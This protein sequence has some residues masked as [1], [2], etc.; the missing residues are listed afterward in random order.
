MEIKK[1]FLLV[2]LFQLFGASAFHSLAQAD[3]GL[4]GMCDTYVLDC[5]PI[6]KTPRYLGLNVEVMP[7]ASNNNVWNWLVDSNTKMVRTPHPAT[8]LRSN[9]QQV[10]ATFS[11]IRS[12]SDFNS[13]RAAV[14][15]DPVKEVKWENYLFS[16]NLPW[17]GNLDSIVD[18][19]V[20][21]K[22]E[23]L[24]AMSYEPSLYPESVLK[25]PINTVSASD[26]VINWAAAASAYEY[27]FACAYRYS[28]KG[29]HYFMMRNEPSITDTLL[30]QSF[31][32][33]ARMARLAIDDVMKIR[34]GKTHIQM[35]GPAV[36]L[37]YE[38][39]LRYTKDYI[40]ILDVH[41]YETSGAT[42][43]KKLRRGLMNA[44][45]NDL[46]FALTEFGRIG[47]ATDIDESLFGMKASLQVA[48][49]IMNVLSVSQIEDPSFE[50][51]LFYQFQFPATHR[52]YKSL[53]YGDMNLVDWSGGDSPLRSKM[54][55]TPTLEQLQLRNPTP[56][57]S[58]F[59]MLAR[60]TPGDDNKFS[61]YPVFELMEANR[62]VT[63]THEKRTKRNTWPD[64][65]KEK[66]Y[67]NEGYPFNIK[68]LVVKSKD[69]LYINILNQEPASLNN[70]K[71]DFS[72]FPDKYVTAVVRETSLLKKDE[73]ISQQKILNSV[74]HFDI[75]A[76]SFI[77]IIL[78]KDDL[79][80]ITEIR[81]NMQDF[82][83]VKVDSL[84]KFE[85][86]LLRVKGKIANRWIDI[87]DLNVKYQVSRG[88]GFSVNGSGLLQKLDT[89]NEGECKIKAELLNRKCSLNL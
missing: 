11:W 61:S 68:S 74:V 1:I 50:M 32:V 46:K 30:M 62:G 12:K 56:A 3:S 29:C 10:N 67:A 26:G 13:Y 83:S 18:K 51:A 49:L 9:E 8:I 55:D 59:K 47:G 80:A 87:S 60:C 79:D 72:S 89:S 70:I 33:L 20:K 45:K 2:F 64:L 23:P 41:N 15:K 27:Y 52:N 86:A 71:I 39:Y 54:S 17:L 6:A 82:T 4:P 69:R 21:C 25:Q 73:P 22:I 75:P 58:I 66:Y 53:V 78:V 7:Y 43:R 19:L 48:D 16:K 34:G 57:Y 81:W 5:I 38:E 85:T 36:Y 40:D 37:A 44:R 77:Q 42:L 35:L 65:G 84:D 28:E 63:A 14:L 24:L 31:N 88:H 76:E